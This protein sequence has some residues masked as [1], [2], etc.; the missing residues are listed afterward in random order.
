MKERHWFLLGAVL[1]AGILWVL[2]RHAW[3]AYRP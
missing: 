3:E 2:A 1:L